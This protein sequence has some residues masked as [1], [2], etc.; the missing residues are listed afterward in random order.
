MGKMA[1][2]NMVVFQKTTAWSE[3]EFLNFYGAQE[4][5]PRNQFRQPMQPG[6]P[7]RQ[8]YSY[9]VP[10]PHML[11]KYSSTGSVAYNVLQIQFPP[12]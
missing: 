7:V 9:S 1:I 5:I 4:S 8:S 11:F 2:F 12:S 10:S 3:P 6:G